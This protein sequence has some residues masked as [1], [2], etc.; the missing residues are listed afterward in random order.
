[1]RLFWYAA[2]ILSGATHANALPK[3]DGGV[4]ALATLDGCNGL[5]QVVARAAMLHAIAL[6]KEHGIGAVAVRNSGHFGT[7]M[8]FNLAEPRELLNGAYGAIV[9]EPAGST[10]RNPVDGS[11]APTG[12]VADIIT[13]TGSY[14][15]F[16]VMFQDNDTDIG[17]NT[18][19]YPRWVSNF[20]GI[21]Y[22]EDPIFLEGLALD[23]RSELGDLDQVFDS[24][25]HGD[26]NT[27]FNAYTGDDVVIRVGIGAGE[28]A[29]VFGIDGHRFP[30]EPNI[31]GSSQLAARGMLPA[32]SFDAHLIDG[33]GSGI[34]SGA[35]Y[36][37]GNF[38][39]PFLV[40]V[41]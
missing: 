37:L 3:V 27:V 2:R 20:S 41:F 32:Q 15:E 12:V 16:V 14:R 9:V 29:H 17:A 10:W 6:S 24:D 23:S 28:Q 1:M 4:G 34:T 11:P 25:G 36:L 18:M 7:A 30:W 8:F 40:D 38:R 33:A 5:G 19:P 39:M 21:N 31:V 26:P 22:G 13:P 35:D